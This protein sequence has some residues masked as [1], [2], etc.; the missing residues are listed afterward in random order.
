MWNNLKSDLYRMIH[1]RAFYVTLVI[2]FIINLIM[3]FTSGIS[4]NSPFAS[5]MSNKNTLIDYLYYTI[6]SPTYLVLIFVFLSIF[7]N[8]EYTKGFVKNTMPIIH[9]KAILVIERYI[10]NIIA[11]VILWVCSLAPVVIK[12]M[13]SPL[14]TGGI[15]QIGDY[16]IYIVVE[17]LAACTVAS[18]IM[19]LNHLTR[20]KVILIVYACF[21]SMFILYMIETS[22]AVALL[23]DASIMENCMYALS[24]S[25]AHS[26]SWNDYSTTIYLIIIYTLLYNGISYLILKKKDI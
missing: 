10:F 7:H 15:F 24:G 11:I 23:D 22:L 20:S 16:L 12:E 21:Y 1:M 13:I 8:D 2:C 4:L 26:F 6:K 14:S 18:F 3:L 19:M 25:L 17:I 5:F 9:N